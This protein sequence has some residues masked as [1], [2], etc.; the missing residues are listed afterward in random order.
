MTV[1]TAARVAGPDRVHAPGWVRCEGVEVVGV[2]AGDPPA[3]A[4]LDLGDVLVAPGFVDAHCHG[5]GGTSF[6]DGVDAARAVAGVHLRHGTTSVVAS[7][8][9]DTHERQLSAV[10]D[11]APLVRGG[12]LAGLH[13]EGP[14]LAPEHRGAHDPRLLA[15]PSVADARELVAAADGALRMVTIAPELP[16]AS[17]VIAALVEAGVVAAIGHTGATWEQTTLALAAGAT[18]GTHLFNGMRP[19]HHREPGPVIALLNSEAFVEVIADGVHLH[20]SITR[21]VLADA[22]DR[23]VLITDAMAAAGMSDGDYGL[24]PLRVEVRDGVARLAGGGSIA[25]ST[26]TMDAAL[27]HAVLT[28]GV[29]LLDAVRA[30]TATPARMLG[31]ADV[32][33]LREGARA[34]LVVLDDDLR[35]RRVMRSGAWLG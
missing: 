6:Q 11:L 32:G 16:G 21:R 18:V 3:P 35:V 23:A 27:R 10:R 29:P 33:E 1:L 5:G 25:G 17:D 26:L 9:T 31:L 30:A 12:V 7:L 34:D 19:V 2:G 8:V 24:G 20:P 4:D 14:W 22:P 28:A 15:T 13:L